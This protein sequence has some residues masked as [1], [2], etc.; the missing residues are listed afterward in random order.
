MQCVE[1]F[2]HGND[3]KEYRDVNEDLDKFQN[4]QGI[5]LKEDDNEL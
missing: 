4:R 1:T 5:L 3:D 2:Y